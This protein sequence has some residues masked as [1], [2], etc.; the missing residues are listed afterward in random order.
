M[1][2]MS[3]TGFTIEQL[4]ETAYNVY[5]RGLQ[6]KPDWQNTDR[7]FWEAMA[8][9]AMNVVESAMKTSM[10]LDYIDFTKDLFGV[11][12]PDID[13]WWDNL[14]DRQALACEAAA[15]HLINC[16]MRA[17]D[18]ADAERWWANWINGHLDESPLCKP[19]PES[20]KEIVY[21]N[22]DSSGTAS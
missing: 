16:M 21:G 14:E 4:A 13:S 8:E 12:S 6:L 9:R 20:V 17:I 22:S 2:T 15:R 5:V 10:T 3:A 19:E 1:K 18:L 7:M 11:L